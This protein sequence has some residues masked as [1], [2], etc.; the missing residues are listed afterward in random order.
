M[1]EFTKRE[2]FALQITVYLRNRD[3]EKAYELSKAFI[4]RFPSDFFSHYLMAKSAYGLRLFAECISHGKQ[5]YSKAPAPDATR[6]AA[7]L[8]G[9]GYFAS[10]QLNKGYALL[11]DAEKQGSDE[12][13]EEALFIFSFALNKPEESAA[14]LGK[15]SRLNRR[16]A[17]DLAK[18]AS[19]S[20]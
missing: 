20:G 10:G 13:L 6:A 19:N 17:L 15:L 2:S 5:A 1:V 7:I 14:H 8:A 16:L 9:S 18:R 12:S 4:A 11:K 3:Y